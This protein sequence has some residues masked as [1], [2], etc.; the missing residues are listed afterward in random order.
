MRESV[1][2]V[3]FY[4]FDDLLPDYDR[5][6]T[7][8]EE[9][10]YWLG[11]AGFAR[12]EVKR[13]MQWFYDFTQLL[14]NSAQ[15]VRHSE[16]VC[17]FTAEECRFLDRQARDYLHGLVRR[18]VLDNLLLEKVVERL[19]AL[20]EPLDMEAVRWVTALIALNMGHLRSGGSMT[21]Q[22]EWLYPPEERV[23]H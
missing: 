12:D 6:E 1:I 15:T 13:A 17:I 5:P 2:E 10:A 20:E 7:D 16:A 11:E 22:E 21:F 19:L 23:L 9:M 14:A 8:L 18:G 4:L 3:L